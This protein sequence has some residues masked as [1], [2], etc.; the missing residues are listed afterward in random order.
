MESS[1]YLLDLS[2]FPPKTF[3]EYSL[4]L[5]SRPLRRF[6]FQ[7]LHRPVLLE[8]WFEG[9][10]DMAVQLRHLPCFELSRVPSAED[11]A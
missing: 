10:N 2:T 1:H 4:Q 3:I 11:R 7:R 8:A 5:N 9:D 6:L